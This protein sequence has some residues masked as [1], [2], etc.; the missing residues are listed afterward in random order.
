MH[1]KV[2]AIIYCSSIESGFDSL[3]EHSGRGQVDTYS[4]PPPDTSEL[5]PN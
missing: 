4:P 1:G 3:V 5:H 2:N